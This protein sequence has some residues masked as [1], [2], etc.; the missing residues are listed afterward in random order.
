MSGGGINTV[1]TGLSMGGLNNI[2][3]NPYQP[4]P[5]PMFDNKLFES[6]PMPNEPVQG[7]T[8]TGGK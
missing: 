7:F 2:P 6:A 5:Q 1:G 8:N 4:L 3:A